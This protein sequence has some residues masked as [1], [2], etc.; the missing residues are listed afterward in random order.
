VVRFVGLGRVAALGEGDR[1]LVGDGRQR[2]EHLGRPLASA[3]QPDVVA[4][5]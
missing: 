5:H 1:V 3:D 2:R 4:G